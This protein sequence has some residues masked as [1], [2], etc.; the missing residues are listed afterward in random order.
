MAAAIAG[1][2]IVAMAAGFISRAAG[3]TDFTGGFW[4]S[5][6]VLPL[7]GLP[8]AFV[9]VIVLLVVTFVRRQRLARDGR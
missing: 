2:S 8:I 5:V 1:L 6:V 9:L 3:V 7:V 4:A